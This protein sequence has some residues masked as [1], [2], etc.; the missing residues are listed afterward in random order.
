MAVKIIYPRKRY[1]KKNEESQR[2]LDALDEY[3]ESNID[4]P[5]RWLVNFWTNQGI[6]L[7]Y[8][9]L[10][11]IVTEEDVPTNILND[12]FHDYSVLLAEKI[13]PMWRDAIEAGWRSDPRFN[14]MGMDI[15]SAETHVRQWLSTRAGEL[16]TSCCD[17]QVNAIRYIVSEANAKGLSSAE[18]AR[19]IRP[20]IGLN[21]RQAEA[22]LKHYMS[23]KEKLKADHPRMSE[24]TIERRARTSAA[25]YA[26]RQH[27]YRAETIARCEVATAFNQGNDTAIRQAMQEDLF[28][29]MEKEWS[30]AKDGNVCKACLVLEGKRIGMDD[31]FSAPSGRKTIMV[32]LP[33]LHPRCK[34]AVKYVEV[35]EE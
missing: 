19:Y 33:P 4:E 13:T 8:R 2:V 20:V 28:P 14:G 5:M 32:L 7:T 21:E 23:V 12:W 18:T 29:K 25:K 35:K 1:I 30:T 26:E 24:E 16:I 3:L 31:E 10:R 15:N 27:R 6:A 34:C 9:E 17:E 11:S 22:N